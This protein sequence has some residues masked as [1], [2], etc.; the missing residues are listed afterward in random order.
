MLITI[1]VLIALSRMVITGACLSLGW[2]AARKLTDKMD[3]LVNNH[4]KELL[5]SLVPQ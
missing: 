5:K 4:H 1:A 3:E 2:W